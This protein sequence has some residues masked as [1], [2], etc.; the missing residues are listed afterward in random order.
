MQGFE[1]LFSNPYLNPTQRLRGNPITLNQLLYN[2]IIIYL[3]LLE[4][5]S[6]FEMFSRIE[7]FDSFKNYNNTFYFNRI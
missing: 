6:P 2:Y 4:K 7:C 5:S 1:S 3:L